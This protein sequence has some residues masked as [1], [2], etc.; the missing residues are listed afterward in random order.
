MAKC[1]TVAVS[2]DVVVL[3]FV[4][5][6]FGATRLE[7]S[8]RRERSYSHKMYRSFVIQNYLDNSGFSSGNNNPDRA[9]A[10]RLISLGVS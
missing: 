8:T 4:P 2:V 1:R 7:F 9:A 5:L 3:S 6:G 10:R